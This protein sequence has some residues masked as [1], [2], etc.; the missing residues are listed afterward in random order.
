[1]P[2]KTIAQKRALTRRTN[3]RVK[4]NQFVETLGKNPFGLTGTENVNKRATKGISRA[5]IKFMKEIDNIKDKSNV[6]GNDSNLEI[7]KL[8]AGQMK[9]SAALADIESQSLELAKKAIEE[10]AKTSFI[11]TGA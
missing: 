1:M 2:R 8:I 9:V 7:C 4:I 3:T 10:Y 5:V 11:K 6:F